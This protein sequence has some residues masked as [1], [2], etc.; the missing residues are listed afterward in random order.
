MAGLIS[1]I[2]NA[3]MI[4]KGI[5]FLLGVAEVEHVESH[6]ADLMNMRMESGSSLLAFPHTPVG[7]NEYIAIIPSYKGIDSS[8]FWN[9]S[10]VIDILWLDSSTF[11]DG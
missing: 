3:T 8:I 10:D 6:N 5:Q 4:P 1:L 7:N 9:G 11:W 2:H